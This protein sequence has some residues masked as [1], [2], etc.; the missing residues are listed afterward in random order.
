MILLNCFIWIAPL[1][2][3]SI[4]YVMM[5]FTQ[6]TAIVTTIHLGLC[7]HV[8]NKE[9][10][11]IQMYNTETSPKL[12]FD[13]QDDMEQKKNKTPLSHRQTKIDLEARASLESWVKQ[14]C[15]F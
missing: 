7:Y 10:E 9:H 13:I 5:Y 4:Y 14:A 15:L 1:I 2:Y 3:R 6:W 8:A 12:A 11:F